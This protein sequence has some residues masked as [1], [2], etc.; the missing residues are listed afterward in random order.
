MPTVVFAPAIQRHVPI[1]P[2]QV[3][4][5]TVRSALAAVFAE[6]AALRDYILDEQGALRRHVAV[7]VDNRK[8]DPR[9]LDDAIGEAAEIFVVQ[10]LSG[11]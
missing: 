9:Q 1:A 5:Q 4:E 10:A 7:F 3:S 2:R 8:I 6:R 11:G